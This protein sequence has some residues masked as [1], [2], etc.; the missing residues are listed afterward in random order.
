MTN[1]LLTMGTLFGSFAF[2]AC[3]AFVI[4]RIA[5]SKQRERLMQ[6][7][8]FALIKKEMTRF[9]G[10]INR[11]VITAHRPTVDQMFELQDYFASDECGSG[12]ETEAIKYTFKNMQLLGYE[13]KLYKPAKKGSQEMVEVDLSK[14]YVKPCKEMKKEI[15]RNKKNAEGANNEDQEERK[16][17]DMDGPTRHAIDEESK[18]HNIPE[19][20]G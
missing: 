2:V 4:A 12:W 15:K 19:V 7:I 14:L 13:V 11:L 17:G 3:F 9:Q 10:E 5:R 8:A 18:P 1:P 20:I 16:E 6:G